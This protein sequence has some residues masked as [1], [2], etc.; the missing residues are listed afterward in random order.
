MIMGKNLGSMSNG[1]VDGV[2]DS[3]TGHESH[4]HPY[5]LNISGWSHVLA[6]VS[7]VS[8]YRH[9]CP[10][11]SSVDLLV[12]L[13]LKVI[14][15]AMQGPQHE[16]TIDIIPSITRPKFKERDIFEDNFKSAER[17]KDVLVD[18]PLAVQARSLSVLSDS[19][20][21][22]QDVLMVSESNL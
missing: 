1:S 20:L 4:F 7:R 11:I 16:K 13:V 5:M 12:T 6:A 14:Q 18:D 9:G 17:T 8:L 19:Q 2:T 21:R 15:G 10:S 22:T 3:S